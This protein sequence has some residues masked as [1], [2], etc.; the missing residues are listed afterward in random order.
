MQFIPSES[1]RNFE[2]DAV[3][4]AAILEQG[5]HYCFGDARTGRKPPLERG[6]ALKRSSFLPVLF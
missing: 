1:F 2:L 4:F 3:Q 5:N 6:A